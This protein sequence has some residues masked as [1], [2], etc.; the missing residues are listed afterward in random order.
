[1]SGFDGLGGF[2]S[3]LRR[4]RGG[5]LPETAGLTLQSIAYGSPLTGSPGQP[6]DDG[7]LQRSWRIDYE[8]Q[9]AALVVTDS[10]HAKQNEDGVEPGGGRYIQRSS[11]GGRHSV[12]LTRR[13]FQRIVEEAGRRVAGA[14]G[15]VG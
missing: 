14:S 5:L 9:T 13:G 10:E 12:R 1:M 6:V 4:L 2:M 11:T 8:S 15:G 3:R 7:D